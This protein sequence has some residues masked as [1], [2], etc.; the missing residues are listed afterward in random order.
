[1]N[2]A[3]PA[4]LLDLTRLV[5]R[6]GRGPL[7]GVDRVE[8]AYL[9]RFLSD[10]LPFFALVRTRLGFALLD[11]EGAQAVLRA[12]SAGAVCGPAD[13]VSRVLWRGQP[14]RARS[15]AEVR[16]LAIARVPRPLLGTMLRRRLPA[17]SAYFNV[18]HANLSPT[19]IAMVRRA[20]AAEV[21]VLVHDTIP[22]DHPEFS[23]PGIPE[24][25]AR[26]MQA[27]AEG[28]DRVIYTTQDARGLAERHFR[29]F[30]RVP[31]GLVAG[32]GVEPARPTPEALPPGLDRRPFFLCV[33][34]IEPRKNHAFLLDLWQ[35]MHDTRSEAEVPRLILAGTRG[36][37]GPE[38]LGRLDSLPFMGRTVLECPGLPDGAIAALMQRAT[39]LLF[40]TLAEGFGLPLVE[41]AAA[42]LPAICTPLPV[43]HE[44]L[45]DY[46]VYLN[47]GDSYS[48]EQRMGE[49]M[50]AGERLGE[51]GRQGHAI[52]GWDSHFNLVLSNAR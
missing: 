52:P 38:V 2:V 20:L 50:R 25:F 6:L 3:P 15:E 21:S 1:M 36:W 26:K 5:S 13:L 41:A 42:G 51:A 18:G 37:A 17:G 35:R 4:R 9:R 30:G 49:M 47:P 39:A 34:T 11:R 31:P 44:I 32:L 8:H 24:S 48:W 22:L 43:F 46:P 45:G 28:A 40:P 19:A 14:Q 16:R 7:T 29:R 12:A 10:P 33:G 27:V 23:R